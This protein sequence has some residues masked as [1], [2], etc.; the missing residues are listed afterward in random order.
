MTNYNQINVKLM[1]NPTPQEYETYTNQME[2]ALRVQGKGLDKMYMKG[3]IDK[4]QIPKLCKQV[5]KE[6]IDTKEKKEA[7]LKDQKDDMNGL[8]FAYICLSLED[9]S[10]VD[11]IR[12]KFKDNGYEAKKYLDSLY[13]VKQSDARLRVLEAERNEHATAGIDKVTAIT[14]REFITKL[15]NYNDKLKGSD[16]HWSDA[17][18]CT[19]TL[20]AVARTEMAVIKVFKTQHRT[21]GVLKDPDLLAK[22]LG[23]EFEDHDRVEAANA[24]QDQVRALMARV[25]ELEKDKQSLEKVVAMRATA[26]GCNKCGKAHKGEC[27]G[28]LVAKGLKTKEQIIT[29]SGRPA[30][31]MGRIVD[32]SVKAYNERHPP[33]DGGARVLQCRAE[34]VQACSADEKGGSAKAAEVIMDVQAGRDIV[35][36]VDTKAGMHMLP[37][38]DFFPDG[39]RPT[40]LV[41]ECAGFSTIK[42]IGIGDAHIIIEGHQVVL[43]N[44]L[45]VPGCAALIS[46]PAL[47]ELGKVDVRGGDERA[48]VWTEGPNKGFKLHFDKD[49]NVRAKKVQDAQA[50]RCEAYEA[51]VAD[52]ARDDGIPAVVVRGTGGGG[53]QARLAQ[54][55]TV[56]LWGARLPIGPERLRA[57]PDVVTG[58][59]AGLKAATAE[60]LR[61]DGAKDLANA[62][63]I[64]PRDRK[65]GADVD[66]VGQLTQVD[67]AGPYQ[68]AVGPKDMA[69]ARYKVMIVD[70]HSNSQHV[71]F[72][73]TKDK[74]PQRLETHLRYYEGRHGA[75]YKGGTLYCDNEAVLNSDKVKQVC[76]LYGLS[77]RNSCEYEPWQNA[78]PE[79]GIGENNAIVREMLIRGGDGN[80]V[81]RYWAVC[82][83]QAALVHRLTTH[84]GDNN[85][86]PYEVETGREPDVSHIR[87][88]LCLAYARLPLAKREGKLQQQAV[89][90]LHLGSSWD[91]PGYIL[92]VIEPGH[93]LH[94][95][96]ITSTQVVFRE[97][98]FPLRASATASGGGVDIDI[99]PDAEEDDVWLTIQTAD[100][101]DDQAAVPD[102]PTFT[103]TDMSSEAGEDE[104]APARGRRATANPYATNRADAEVLPYTTLAY[105]TAIDGDVAD[106]P[107]AW[108]PRGI[109]QVMR[110]EEGEEKRGWLGVHAE[111]VSTHF[112][113]GVF[114]WERRPADLKEKDLYRLID[115]WYEKADGRKK[116]RIVLDGAGVDSDMHGRT[117]SPTS[118]FT[119]VRSMASC[120]ALHGLMFGSADVKHAYGN[121][122]TADTDKPVYCRSIPGVATPMCP[123]TGEKMVVRVYNIN[124]HPTAGR[125]WY[126]FFKEIIEAFPGAEVVRS[127]ADHCLFRIKKGEEIMLIVVY[128]DDILDMAVKGSALRA[129]FYTYLNSRVPLADFGQN[130]E[131]EFLGATVRQHNGTVTLT[132]PRH[133]REL[134]AR[135][136]TA[137]GAHTAY[138]VPV[139]DDLP[140]QVEEAKSGHGVDISLTKTFAGL[141]CTMLYIGSTTRPDI[142]Y[143]VGMLT[144]C[145]TCPTIPLMRAA[146]RIMYYLD[147]T[148]ALG[149]RYAVDPEGKQGQRGSYAGT[150]VT[151]MSDADHAVK[152][153]TSGRCFDAG[154]G[155]VVSYGM[156]KQGSVALSS[157]EAELNAAS[158]A[159]SEA[160]HLTE[161][162]ADA[163]FPLDGPVVM[164]LDNKA[165]IDMA[166]DPTH[167]TKAKHILRRSFFI[168]ELVNEA[169]VEVKHVRSENNTADIFTKPLQK[170]SFLK[171]RSTML[172]M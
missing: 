11:K 72:M 90:C 82:S 81:E 155:A 58:A 143:G 154:A 69:G 34:V 36:G 129:Q 128:V 109:K 123:D 3:K 87:V 137:G 170:R 32:S 8:L 80:D 145:L 30:D 122:P 102:S 142:M 92:E 61:E 159:A 13:N 164:Y 9:E 56:Q 120:A 158:E 54:A 12:N 79:R 133:I 76:V 106:K 40:S 148:K 85:I 91:K 37:S 153:S 45:C 152:R 25:A 114:K 115:L 162:H 86:T 33:K 59:P 43:S 166:H 146:E 57:L 50:P 108:A 44:T 67:L 104:T 172:N 119:T 165:A 24:Q 131:F 138:T 42:P 111:E 66:H 31:M 126:L 132:S 168:R 112:E 110:M 15:T 95:K 51:V 89:R 99:A 147:G 49:W 16:H 60:M 53:A 41:I 14:L 124:G 125:N 151:G 2:N 48:L 150:K 160:V 83:K 97:N 98:I 78:R 63:R 22:E 157:A 101:E 65:R 27:F 35:V 26:T 74:F 84:R 105:S 163:G 18:I 77:M 171:H 107:S 52:M 117:H 19:K 73:D 121:A 140:S 64:H 62:P 10:L 156:K 94:G 149:L 5:E 127:F 71:A 1:K 68:K 7:Y 38:I 141:V 4:V 113:K 139:A 88:M 29:E 169:R 55:D 161:L 144:R 28:E 135:Y 70:A 136:G 75:T 93:A 96:Y 46:Y 103:D 20:D 23:E 47:W 17:L 167:L 116:C 21:D 6:E 130:A 134:N 100:G 39:V 118:N